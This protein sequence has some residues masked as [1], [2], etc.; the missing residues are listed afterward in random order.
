MRR[1]NCAL[2][3]NAVM[4]LPSPS[5]YWTAAIGKLDTRR[6][7]EPSPWLVLAPTAMLALSPALRLYVALVPSLAY[8]VTEVES[9]PAATTAFCE[10][11][12]TI[13]VAEGGT[14]YASRATPDT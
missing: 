6:M 1:P 9:V 8:A 11:M 10:R 2:D 5:S 7:A 3:Q 14:G 13:S 4:S 12:P